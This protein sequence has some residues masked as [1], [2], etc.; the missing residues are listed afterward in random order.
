MRPNHLLITSAVVFVLAGITTGQNP[1]TVTQE[2]KGSPC[3]NIVALTGDVKIDCSSLT[4]AQ[5]KI[6]DSIPALLRN[7]IAH[8]LDA[9]KVIAKLDD[10]LKM[11]NPNLPKK[12]YSCD[13][14]VNSFGPSTD[15]GGMTQF[16]GNADPDFHQMAELYNSE[17]WAPLLKMCLAKIDANPAWLTPFLFC[18]RAYLETGDSARAKDMLRKFDDT[19]GPGNRSERCKAAWEDLHKALP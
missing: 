12:T 7:I 3:S 19:A 14:S 13:G 15:G 11:E 16:H 10:C 6:I 9:D 1:P 8:Q 5:Q 2:A 4:S 17:N 18:S